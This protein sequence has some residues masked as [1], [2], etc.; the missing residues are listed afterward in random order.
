VIDGQEY[1]VTVDY[2]LSE[3]VFE[4]KVW[5]SAP[6]HAVALAFLKEPLSGLDPQKIERVQVKRSLR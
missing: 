1:A 4:V 2:D 5:A 6:Y 3:I